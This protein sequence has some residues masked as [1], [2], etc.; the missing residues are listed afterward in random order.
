MCKPWKDAGYGD[1]FRQPVQVQREMGSPVRWNR[2]DLPEDRSPKGRKKDTRRWC[3]G[4][5]GVEHVPVI[6]RDRASDGTEKPCEYRSLVIGRDPYWVCYHRWQCAT[7]GKHLRWMDDGLWTGIGI[8]DC[9][10]AKA[11]A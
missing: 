5:R 3:R 7:C 11:R 9:P 6:A 8:A 10:D 1:A 4:K 2:H